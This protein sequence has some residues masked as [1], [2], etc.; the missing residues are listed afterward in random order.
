MLSHSKIELN[1]RAEFQLPP[2]SLLAAFRSLF[3]NVS[4]CKTGFNNSIGAKYSLT[5]FFDP[6]ISI[7]SDCD[8]FIE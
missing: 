5:D 8:I 3:N 7:E 4:A 6:T 2:L 1:S